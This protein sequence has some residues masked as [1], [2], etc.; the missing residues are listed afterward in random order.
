[1]DPQIKSDKFKKQELI[2]QVTN[3]TDKG[4]FIEFLRFQCINEIMNQL[5]GAVKGDFVI[6]K[7]KISGRKIGKNEDESFYTNLDVIEIKII[8]K[9]LDMI[10]ADRVSKSD[11][12]SDKF[13]GIDADEEDDILSDKHDDTIPIIDDL[14]F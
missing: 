10:E 8:N 13:P 14:P 1:M 9:A 12:Y 6:C 11:S 4:T 2:L 5:D 7:F 3:P